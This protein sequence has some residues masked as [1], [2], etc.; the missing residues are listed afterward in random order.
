MSV[1]AA[2]S[3]PLHICR[4]LVSNPR[5]RLGPTARAIPHNTPCMRRAQVE[6]GVKQL[7]KAEAT[8]KSGRALPCIALLLVLIVIFLIMMIV[9]HA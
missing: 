6:E 1:G 8:Q 7:V 5:P 2:P 9:R 4:A 3:A